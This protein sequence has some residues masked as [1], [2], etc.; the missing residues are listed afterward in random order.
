[1]TADP[2]R[3]EI[4]TEFMFRIDIRT[5]A[6]RIVQMPD[7][8]HGRLVNVAVAGGTVEGPW[9]SGIVLDIGGDW[10]VVHADGEVGDVTE[11]DCSLVIR[12]HD[13]CLVQMSYTGI[14]YQRAARGSP[15]PAGSVLDPAGYYFRTAPRFRTGASEYDRLNRTLAVASG[16]HR[17]RAGPVYDVFAVL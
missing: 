5:D 17:V 11:L 3:L 6:A 10:G 1:M 15:G 2:A 8:P 12:T 4:A 13:G 16:Y 9:L 7:T 14:S